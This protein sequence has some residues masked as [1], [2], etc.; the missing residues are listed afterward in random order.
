MGI[1]YDSAEG[2]ALCGALT[3]IMCGRLRGVGRDGGASTGRSRASPEHREP[4]LRVMRMHRDAAYD[5]P[6]RLRGADRRRRSASTHA[7][8]PTGAA[9]TRAHARLGPR[10]RPRRAARLPQRAGTVLAPTGTIGLLMDC[11]TT[12]IEPD[13]ALV[14]FKKLAGGG[15]F[16]IV[17]QSVPQALATSA[18]RR[19][20]SRRSSPT[21][22]GTTRS[23]ARRTSTPTRSTAKGFGRGR[24]REDRGGAARRLRPPLRLQPVDPRRGVLHRH[25][26]IRRRSCDDP[27]FD[28]LKHLG[29]T[30]AQIDEAND[31]VI[32]RMT[33]E[34]APHLQ[35]EHYAVF[36][37]ANRCGKTGKRFLAPISHV[38]M[39]AAAQPFLS[40]AISKTVNLPNDATV[41][42][43]QK[44]YEQGWRLGLKAVA[45]YRDGCKPSQPLSTS[46]IEGR[47]GA[48]GGADRGAASPSAVTRARRADR[49]EDRSPRR[50]SAPTPAAA[51]RRSARASRRRR[52]SAATRSSS[53]PASTRT[54]RSAR[55]SSTCTR[56][57]RP[58]AR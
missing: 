58:S 13:F 35:A 2:R 56:R 6:R 55:S 24:A 32:G 8:C 28:L 25:L 38:R 57:A 16:K 5:A 44:V 50:S 41:E 49:R 14:K 36:D 31:Y 47:R 21:S 18:T 54:A 37:C 15:Y 7:N 20:R 48:R 53:A 46:L 27:A 45:L 51:C 30:Q 9:R 33:I 17:N 39:M 10:R 52:A 26:G 40:G 4:M 11:D 34:G 22:S 29:F 3:A 19:A 12:G 42:D 43:V 1:P 23:S